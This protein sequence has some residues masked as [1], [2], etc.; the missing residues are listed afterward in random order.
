MDGS[1]GSGSNGKGAG[2][3]PD[4]V[5]GASLSDRSDRIPLMVRDSNRTRRTGRGED[6]GDGDD[7]DDDFMNDGNDGNRG[8]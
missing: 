2:S 6:G 5:N 4:R 8:N 7:D 1:K 3:T